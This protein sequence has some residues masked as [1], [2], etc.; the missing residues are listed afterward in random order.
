MS[1]RRRLVKHNVNTEAICDL[2][3]QRSFE[4]DSASLLDIL[5]TDVHNSKESSAVLHDNETS[6]ENYI[7]FV[8]EN[9]EM[10]VLKENFPKLTALSTKN[11]SNITIKTCKD[12]PNQSII[13]KLLDLLNHTSKHFYHLPFELMMLPKEQRKDNFFSPI[14]DYLES[15]HLSSN[16]KSQP[17]II[18]EAENII[19]HILYRI[20]DR[21][22]RTIDYKIALC[23]PL[24]L[25]HKRFEIYHSRLLTTHQ[26]LTK[27]YYK[28]LQEKG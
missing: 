10:P 13:N 24:Q 26:G 11:S 15:N 19:K 21:T 8:E 14:T 22:A 17:S 20:V 18:S 25:S 28:I 27:T 16:L 12:M 23:I 3:S 7:P 5:K 9:V 6:S 1:Q 2:G 4:V